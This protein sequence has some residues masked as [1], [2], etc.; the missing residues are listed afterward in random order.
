M[1]ANGLESVSVHV[2]VNGL[3]NVLVNDLVK[4]LANIQV[5]VHLKRLRLPPLGRAWA[6]SC[7]GP[8]APRE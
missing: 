7:A 6:R 8:P 4:V 5:Q 2:L 3:V 1:L